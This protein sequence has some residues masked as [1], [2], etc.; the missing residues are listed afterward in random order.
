MCGSTTCKAN[1]IAQ[2]ESK[3]LPPRSSVAMP[4]AVANQC[5]EATT[6]NV[7]L[8]SGRVVKLLMGSLE[9]YCATILTRVGAAGEEATIV[10]DPYGL[11][12]ANRF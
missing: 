7:P 2:A 3:A 6:P 11:R 4:A 9:T 8:I 12:T 10:V 5:V 1:P